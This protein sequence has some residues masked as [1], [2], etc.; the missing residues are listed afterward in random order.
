MGGNR[1]TILVLFTLIL[2]ALS[3]LAG[4]TNE[5]QI[6]ALPAGGKIYTNAIIT[7]VTPAYAVVN[8]QEGIV[9]IPMSNMP[10]VYQTRFGYTPE[11][12]AQ[13][14]DQQK[15]IQQK[16]WQADLARQAAVQSL[17]GTNRPVRITAII[18]ENSFNGVPLCSAE[19]I[20]DSILVNNL[21]DSVRQFLAGCRKLQADIAD[22]EQQIN[23]LKASEESAA[24]TVPQPQMG[25]NLFVENG[26][27]Y[28]IVRAP[29]KED[30]ATIRQN[31]EDR[32]KALNAELERETT[33]F[34][35]S[36]TIM[37]HP[38]GVFYGSKP[39]W[40]CVGVPAAT[41]K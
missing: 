27:G 30:P 29:Q 38:S 9:Q 8:C 32:L 6:D 17:A 19:G 14:L 31:A 21:P 3:A 34:N 24:K 5:I 7:S 20:S 28:V 36:T 4:T 33:N 35:R 2:S 23:N 37:A 25:K 26:A 10:A 39:I 15:R 12:A 41:A 16:Q 11:K 40:I 13:F 1:E 22:C 18:D